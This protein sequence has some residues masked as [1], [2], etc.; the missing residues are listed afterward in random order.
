IPAGFYY[1]TFMWPASRWMSYERLIRRAAGLGRAPVGPDPDRYDEH[2]FDADLLVAGGGPA[3]IAAA[4]AAARQGARVL[5]ADEGSA[6]G[7]SLLGA[8][9]IIAGEPAAVWLAA[10]LAELARASNVTL[11]R[12]ATV[13]GHYDH[14]LFAVAE[15]VG[16]HAAGKPRQRFWKVRTERA[17]FAT[18]AIERPLVFPNNDR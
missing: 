3:G 2:H 7:G 5:L 8:P 6:F 11:L 16:H 12:R 4:L 14:G 10:A 1:K 18:G 17:V 15:Q 13:F 9:A